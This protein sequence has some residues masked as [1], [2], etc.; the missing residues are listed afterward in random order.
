MSKQKP[1]VREVE[2]PAQ[3]IGE[4]GQS[5]EPRKLSLR[6]NIVL[7][8]KILVGATILGLLI[9]FLDILVE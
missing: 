1:V 9:W 7:T 5:L 4:A 3:P 6:E 2:T 8:V